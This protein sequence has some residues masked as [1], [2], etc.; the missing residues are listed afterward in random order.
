[1]KTNL[2]Y[3]LII[4]L[5]FGCTSPSKLTLVDKEPKREIDK[6]R[7]LELYMQGSMFEG[8]QEFQ[9][10]IEAYKEALLYDDADAIYFALAL[11][12]T[13]LENFEDAVIFSREAIKRDTL[14]LDYRFM[15]AENLIMLG[16]N[17][18]ALNEYYNILKID[19]TN[20]QSQLALGIILQQKEPLKALS[21]FEKLILKTDEPLEIYAR[22]SVINLSLRRF[23]Q[24]A[25]IY[26]AM[27]KLQPNNNYLKEDLADIY[28]SLEKPDSSLIIFDFLHKQNKNDLKIN[29]M[30]AE[31]YLSKNNWEKAQYHFKNVLK[32]DSL[33]AETRWRI[34]VVYF[35][36]TEKD[37]SLLLETISQLQTMSNNYPTDWRPKFYLG[38]MSIEQNK[39][40]EAAFYFDSVTNVASWNLD[41]WTNLTF[42]YFQKEEYT[43]VIRILEKALLIFPNESKIYFYLGIAQ[44]Q[45]KNHVEAIKRLEQAK[46]LN[47]KDATIFSS[48]GFSYDA[49]K[50]FAN[51]D[52][53]YQNALRLDS[54]NATS[55]NNYAYSLAERNLK[56]RDALEMSLRTI[57]I[58]STNSSFF[59]TLG[60]IYFKLALYNEA[61]QYLKKAIEFSP[62]PN[63]IL[64]DHLGDLYEKLNNKDLA[65][66]N[67]KKAIETDPTL[68]SVKN[69]IIE[70]DK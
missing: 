18:L 24:V 33:T 70:R 39:T 16:R 14:K 60:W 21:I 68:T 23:Q 13:R 29:G 53:A 32:N 58:D 6:S 66:Y 12:S 59:D 10:A 40:D 44:S 34:A 37:S 49:L 22:M 52:I 26:N 45:N 25:N 64:F 11:N 47:P 55:L 3:P 65:I 5:F 31:I 48:L 20:F 46:K 17:D 36:Q 1:M 30:L 50:D 8:N 38:L 62:E 27:I 2:I 51:S 67:W 4:V 42:L 56:L 41:A 19:S 9:K 61:L 63:A 54:L 43:Q 69:K 35:S 57:I 7:A 28:I 15:L